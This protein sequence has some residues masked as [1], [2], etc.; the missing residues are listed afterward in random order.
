MHAWCTR[1]APRTDDIRVAVAWCYGDLFFGI[2]ATAT[3]TI[4]LSQ[5]A[6]SAGIISWPASVPQA[7]SS[8]GHSHVVSWPASVPQAVS[9]VGHSHVMT[10]PAS[11]PPAVAKTLTAA[12]QIFTGVTGSVSAQV[13]TG[14]EG[15]VSA[16]TFTGVLNSVPA[17]V[18]SG[19][20]KTIAILPP[21]ITCYLWERTA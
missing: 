13:F 15:T 11:V 16:Q 21:Y 14:I 1:R 10:W 12:S 2:G 7:V 18:F 17:Q 6:S 4:M 8:V 20:A 9:S 3:G 19:I 5:S